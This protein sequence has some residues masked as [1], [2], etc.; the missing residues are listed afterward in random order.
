MTD[1]ISPDFA[2]HAP[3]SAAGQHPTPVRERVCDSATDLVGD[4]KERAMAVGKQLVDTVRK[5]PVP[6]AVAAVGAG[7]L[8]WWLL[9]RRP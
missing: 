4:A 2:S 7:L 1:P 3:T 9:S 5:H 6:T 8:V